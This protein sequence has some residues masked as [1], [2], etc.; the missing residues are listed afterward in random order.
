MALTGA[1]L[2]IA[3]LAFLAQAL[4]ATSAG[5]LGGRLWV[6]EAV[7]IGI[8]LIGLAFFAFLGVPGILEAAQSAIP[9][10]AGY[11]P[12]SDL[13]VLAAMLIAGLVAVRIL[14]A[15]FT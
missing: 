11:G 7:S 8:A 3:L 14:A 13:S 2:L 4:K 1:I 15:T 5:A 12:I 10:S 9:S 6:Q